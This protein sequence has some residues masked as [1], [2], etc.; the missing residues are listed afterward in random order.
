MT[1]KTA[2]TRNDFTKQRMPHGTRFEPVYI[3]EYDKNGH[4]Y[5]K[6][7]GVTDTQEIIQANLESTKI[8][9]IIRRC[10]DP[11]LLQ[12]KITQFVDATN[13]PKNL[14]EVQNIILRVKEEFAKLPANVREK[15]GNSADVYA[16]KYGTQEWGAALGLLEAKESVAAP[17][18]KK[19]VTENGAE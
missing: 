18:I 3:M 4:K 14:Y 2:Y 8:E 9:N 10:V 19:E 11:Q 7:N 12:A 5:L 13:M 15:F 6:Q 17:E 16:A 1:F